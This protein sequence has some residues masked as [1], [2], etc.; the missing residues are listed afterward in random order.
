[1]RL[2]L[3][4]DRKTSHLLLT[5][6]DVEVLQ[7][8]D[9][10]LS[11]L[12]SLTDLLSGEDYVTVSAVLPLIDL[13]VTKLSKEHDDDTPLTKDIKKAIRE[14]L[15]GRNQEESAQELLRFAM[16]IDPRFKTKHMSTF[17]ISTVKQKIMD[18]YLLVE[19]DSH[20][21]QT[22]QLSESQPPS[23]RRNLGTLFKENEIPAPAPIE[24]GTTEEVMN[25]EFRSYCESSRLDFEADPL[26]WWKSNGL[27]FPN[28]S[29]FATKYLC[30][31]ATSSSS[32]RLFS[33]SGNIL[34]PSRSNMKPDMLNMLTFLSKN[35]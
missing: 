4:S 13:I 14:D 20:L 24:P 8:I 28:L 9:K 35:L 12:S 26:E 5:W 1:M 6:Q 7:S 29:K 18:E 34:S 16:F 30:V 15:C 27:T 33:R 3:S 11:P 19:L 17:D 21:E 2:V 32:E 22:S 10:A 31:M 23:K 25:S